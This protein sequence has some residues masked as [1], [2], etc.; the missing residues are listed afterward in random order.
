MYSTCLFCNTSLGVNE[1]IENF[2]VGRRI[3]FDS[4]T[5]RLWAVCRKCER[6]NLSPLET[7]WEAIDEAER[8]FRGTKL[9][10]STDNI[11]LAQLRDGTELVRIGKPVRTEFAA[12]RYG[13]QFGRRWRKYA[14][15]SATA[16]AAPVG[17][18]IFQGI[19][20]GSWLMHTAASDAMMPL[21]MG[22]TSVYAIGTAV[23]LLR[24]IRDRRTRVNVRD[25]AGTVL[26]VPRFWMKRSVIVPANGNRG[27]SLGLMH[28]RVL[29]P[30]PVGRMQGD[31]LKQ[32]HWGDAVLSNLTGD[33]ALRALSTILPHVNH[34]GGTERT[35]R[36]AVDSITDA[37]DLSGIISNAPVRRW[38]QSIHTKRWERNLSTLPASIRLALEMSLHETDERRAMEGEL[39]ELE[40]RWKEADAIAKIA[41]EMFL[42]ENMDERLRNLSDEK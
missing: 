18:L 16:A 38:S 40:N 32:Q 13:N 7:R 4:D 33:H 37:K 8:L 22:G 29:Q 39:H 28:L 19:N 26:R 15:G 35:V 2:P 9:R 27:L 30:G 11:G 34:D 20:V 3:A 1:S 5:G 41:D 14:A 25:D 21:M 6:W 10:V 17:H 24:N 42:P 12:W 31:P 23:T 36:Q